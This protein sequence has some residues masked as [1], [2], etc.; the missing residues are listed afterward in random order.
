[1]HATDER[2]YLGNE[3]VNG[4]RYIAVLL[5]GGHIGIPCQAWNYV[6]E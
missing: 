5:G 6:H 3:D 1:M 4:V 2:F